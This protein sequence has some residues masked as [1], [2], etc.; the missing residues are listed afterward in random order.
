[1]GEPKTGFQF[2]RKV[3]IFFVEE[4]GGSHFWNWE[5]VFHVFFSTKGVRWCILFPLELANLSWFIIVFYH[6]LYDTLKAIF[7]WFFEIAP[8]NFGRLWVWRFFYSFKFGISSQ[9]TPVVTST[10]GV[11]IPLLKR[12]NWDF[13]GGKE[14]FVTPYWNCKRSLHIPWLFLYIENTTEVITPHFLPKNVASRKSCHP[15]HHHQHQASQ[16]RS[17]RL[18]RMREFQEFERQQAEQEARHHKSDSATYHPGQI[19]PVGKFPNLWWLFRILFPKMSLIQVLELQFAQKLT[20]SSLIVGCFFRSDLW[21][22]ESFGWR[23]I[24]RSICNVVK[25]SLII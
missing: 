7:W 5:A 17:L 18:E 25:S 19:S 13:W 15:F 11:N 16:E 14:T 6:S 1:M 22:P 4:R 3:H 9:D 8:Q 24:N 10:F 12:I 20:I 23:F 2:T 21:R